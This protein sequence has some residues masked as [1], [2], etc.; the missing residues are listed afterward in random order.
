MS[1]AKDVD[2]VAFSVY[3]GGDY[4]VYVVDSAE[5]LVGKLVLAKR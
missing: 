1:V 4:N 2:K 5:A 3:E